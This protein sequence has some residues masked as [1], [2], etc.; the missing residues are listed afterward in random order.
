MIFWFALLVCLYLAWTLLI[1]G[2][3][4][5]IIL[6]VGGWIGIYSLLRVYFPD[7]AQIVLTLAG[8]GY[9]WAAMIPTIICVLALAHTRV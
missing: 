3:L 1:G 5:K 6:F 7:S 4:W 8:H 9:S 2:L